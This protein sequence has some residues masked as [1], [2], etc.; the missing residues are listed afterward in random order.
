M[1]DNLSGLPTDQSESAYADEGSHL[2]WLGQFC[3]I[4][5]CLNA[6]FFCYLGVINPNIFYGSLVDEGGEVENLTFIAFL[7]GGFVLFAAALTTRRLFSR[8][9]YVL[10]GMTLLFFAGEEISYGQ[11]VIG[12][13]T[14]DFLLGLNTHGE[15]NIHNLETFD[16]AVQQ[17]AA[18]VMLCVAACTA[19]FLRKTRILGISTPPIVLTLTLLVTMTYFYTPIIDIYRSI[20]Y[21]YRGL[22]LLLLLVGLFS[23]NVRLFIATAASLSISLV[24]DHLRY[25]EMYDHGDPIRFEEIGEYLFSLFCFFYALHLLL[26]QRMA[27][28][29]IAALVAA[30]KP[31]AAAIPSIRIKT[32]FLPTIERKSFAG[33][34]IKE[35][36][37][38]PWTGIC[39]LIIAGSIGFALM[40]QLHYRADA[41]ALEETRSL[42]R[43]V[44]PAA[45]S[46]FDIYIDG[47]NLRYFKQPCSRD[48]EK[49]TFF[50]GIFPVNVD[51][52]PAE[53]RPYDFENNDFTFGQYGQRIDDACAI[54]VRL[55]DYEIARITTGQYTWDHNGVAT[56]LWSEEFPYYSASADDNRAYAAA[57]E[58]TRLLT[59]T[60]EPAAR[61]NFDVYI[62]G[63]DLHYFRQPCVHTDV[64]APFFLGVFPQNVDDLPAERRPYDFENNDF[65][66]GQYGQTIDGACAITVRLPDYEIARISTG[67]YTWDDNGVATNLW[68][69]DFPVNK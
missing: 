17:R 53:R 31:V 64:D 52:L 8:C 23:G 29:K 54:T 35:E 18:M 55:P 5:F 9:V 45:L 34:K 51:D 21:G 30:F 13:E 15:F 1:S 41:A 44:A 27:R 50:L 12:F 67:Q 56:N 11:R 47:R 42:T 61:S 32:P 19:F 2:T 38:T 24:I 68:V 26:D 14:P 65:A 62:D 66:F 46:N 63:R 43:T 49:T 10:G 48:A 60:T 7:L 16:A 20:N 69:A 36:A 37:L 28:Q 25:H 58:E 59:Q 40:L 33:I 6:L 22:L 3:Y 39:A 4:L 57:F